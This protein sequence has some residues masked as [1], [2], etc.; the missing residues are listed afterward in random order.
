MEQSAQ[1]AGERLFVV[2][3]PSATGKNTVFDALQALVPFVR[4]AITVTT[5]LPRDKEQ[6]GVDYYFVTKEEF[7]RRADAGAFVEQNRYAD[8]W[9]ATPKAELCADEAEVVVLIIDVHGKDAV[10]AAY[11]QA[12]SVFLM[13]PSMEELR[14]RILSRNQNSPEDVERR[15]EI[16][17][18]EMAR[19]QTYDYV[20]VNDDVDR[21]A[22]ELAAI[23]Q[24]QI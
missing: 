11:P 22:A 14:R 1:Y 3:A 19:A 24:A 5:R 10:T 8:H 15:L 20:L 18:E 6:D 4:R 13:P 16:A 21:C 2:S 12:K 23:V 17:R 9:Y 7:L